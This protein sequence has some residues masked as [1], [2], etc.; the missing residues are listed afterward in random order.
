M[1]A[2]RGSGQRWKNETGSAAEN[3]GGISMRYARRDN[4]APAM[5][6]RVAAS[7]TARRRAARHRQAAL[8]SSRGGPLACAAAGG[9]VVE[10]RLA[11]R[12][13]GG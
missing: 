10:R 12:G 8:A 4:R 3:C 1:A 11:S 9:A 13:Y 5:Q 7:G 2:R 6:R